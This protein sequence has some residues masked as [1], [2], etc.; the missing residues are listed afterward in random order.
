MRGSMRGV[1]VF[2][3]ETSDKEV[4]VVVV[5]DVMKGVDREVVVVVD[6][7]KDVDKEVVVV[8][9]VSIFTCDILD[10]HVCICDATDDK[11]VVVPSL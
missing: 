7:M 10:S 3:L 4:E 11:E 5:V 1:V 6:V 9:D 8:V 2:S